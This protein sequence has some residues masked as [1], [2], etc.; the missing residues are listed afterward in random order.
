LIQD[1]KHSLSN[2]NTQIEARIAF[3]DFVNRLATVSIENNQK[4][5][6]LRPE[7]TELSNNE[8]LPIEETRNVSINTIGLP[9]AEKMRSHSLNSRNDL[10]ES[11]VQTRN[12]CKRNDS[13]SGINS[14][15]SFCQQYSDIPPQPP[16]RRRSMTGGPKAKLEERLKHFH[17]EK[18][19]KENQSLSPSHQQEKLKEIHE[20]STKTPGRVRIQTEKINKMA[21][22]SELKPPM[23]SSATTTSNTRT[24]ARSLVKDE[25]TDSGSVQPLDPSRRRWI[26]ASSN[27]DYNELVLLLK[28]DPKLCSYK[29]F[30]NGYTALHW[31]AKFNKSQ[32]IHLIAGTYGLNPNIKSFAGFTA[33]HLAAIHK[34]EYIMELLIKSFNADPEIR[35]NSGKKAT[36]YLTNKVETN[37]TTTSGKQKNGMISNQRKADLNY[38]SDSFSTPLQTSTYNSSTVD[39]YRPNKGNKVSHHSIVRKSS[40]LKRKADKGR[41]P[42][43][44]HL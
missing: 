20:L 43:F 22:L 17:E 7:F 11:M 41:R 3:K 36:S 2:P 16:P 18:N 31:A 38:G 13:N 23:P 12:Q 28:E 19:D 9:I 6:I 10:N 1:F 4:Y 32:V 24:K 27:C 39:N 33:L 8:S 34:N 30:T 29:D 14:Q 25:D 26:I 21:S 44:P 40:F 42:N 35:D 37:T 5:L 15:Y